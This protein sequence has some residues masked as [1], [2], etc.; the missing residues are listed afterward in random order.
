MGRTVDQNGFTDQSSIPF[1]KGNLAYGYNG[2]NNTVNTNA[3]LNSTV[4]K[5]YS[6]N[7]TNQTINHVQPQF[8][9][10]NGIGY[11]TAM[12]SNTSLDNGFRR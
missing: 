2:N 12:Y 10:Q 8:Q 1:Q 5:A 7:G 11:G 9:N 4:N 6:M 3:Y